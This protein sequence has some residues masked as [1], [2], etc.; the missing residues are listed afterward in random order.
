ME[1]KTEYF[2][3]YVEGEKNGNWKGG[4]KSYRGDFEKVK[5]Q[6]FAGAQVCAICGTSKGIHIHHI[7]PYRLTKDNGTDN[8]IPL[9][10]KHH[11]MVE[12]ATLKFIELF[13]CEGLETA[14]RYL[15]LLLRGYQFETAAVLMGLRKNERY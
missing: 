11:K 9:C 2:H 6:H 7:I 10:R 15:N 13:D 3:N 14:K 4:A 5:K 12:H 1:C 8:L